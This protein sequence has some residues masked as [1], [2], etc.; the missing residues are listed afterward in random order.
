MRVTKIR[1][2]Q[3]RPLSFGNIYFEAQGDININDIDL[4]ELKKHLGN[5]KVYAE[6]KFLSFVIDENF[7]LTFDEFLNE[8]KENNLLKDKENILD[9]LENRSSK[10]D[11]LLKKDLEEHKKE[12]ERLNAKNEDYAKVTI[13][14]EDKVTDLTNNIDA[15]VVENESLAR[16]ILHELEDE[17][18]T[19]DDLKVYATLHN[20]DT[21]NKTAKNSILKVINESF[22]S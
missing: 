16:L 22:D 5:I 19:A 13:E 12:V 10:I 7:Q 8:L 4:I 11:E 18:V 9:S 1:N 17:E 21:G 6:N 3:N 20:I 2:N 14:L 15:L